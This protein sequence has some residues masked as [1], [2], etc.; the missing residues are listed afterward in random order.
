MQF[1]LNFRPYLWYAVLA[2]KKANVE[3]CVPK[4]KKGFHQY[5]ELKLRPVKGNG[6]PRC[7]PTGR[8]DSKPRQSAA[9]AS[10]KLEASQPGSRQHSH[11][12]HARPSQRVERLAGQP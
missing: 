8:P 11:S 3:A 5:V 6:L 2:Q 10:G 9:S 7:Q 4:R 1:I 12:S